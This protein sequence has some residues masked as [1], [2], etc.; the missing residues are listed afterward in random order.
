MNQKGR[1][2]RC[3][4]GAKMEAGS[5][6]HIDYD[7]FNASNDKLIETTKEDSAKEHEIHDETKT[8]IP[9]IT[10]VG[11][12]RL[13]P[14]FEEHLTEAKVNE[15]YKFEIE[16]EKAYGERDANQ[17]DT[18]SQNVLLRSVRDPNTLG[19][20]SP[21]EIGGKTGILQFMSAGRAR[22]DYNHPLA[23]VT[24][25]YN[26]EIVKVVED[27]EEKIKTL[28]NMNTGKDDFE[29]SFDG[30][31]LTITLSEEMA[32]DQNW[33]YAKFALV[34]TLRDHVGVSKVIFREVHEPRQIEEE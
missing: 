27:R 6:V 12:G 21:V 15:E 2:G 26:Y 29:I 10:I 17:I 1:A 9:M 13:I 23:G 30:D 34:R 24:L 8:Y 11:D 4:T 3:R 14:G 22:I 18:I 28:L 5:I 31:D 25:R 19:I 7:L 32:Y 16:P 20:G 33:A